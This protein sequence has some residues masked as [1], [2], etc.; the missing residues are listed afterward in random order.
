MSRFLDLAVVAG[1][2]ALLPAVLCCAPVA[3]A[4]EVV[5]ICGD[6][7]ADLE[8]DLADPIWLLRYSLLGGEPP[9]CDG[10][11]KCADVNKDHLIDIGDP[12]YLFGWLL[13]GTEQEPDC[14]DAHGCTDPTASNFDPEA[15]E[16]DGSCEYRGCTDPAAANHDPR[17]TVDDGSCVY[18]ERQVDGFTF[19]ARNA[20]GYPEYRHHE[21]GLIFVLLPG[22]EATLGSPD[23][24]CERN[25]DEGPVHRVSLSPFLIAKYELSQREWRDVLLANPSF[26][27]PG[28]EGEQYLPQELLEEGAWLNLP[29]ETVSWSDCR[30]YCDRTGLEMPT[31]AQWEYACRAGT[32]TPFAF[33]TTLTADEANFWASTGYCGAAGEEPV[34]HTLPINALGPNEFGLYNVHGNV[35]E[36]CADAYSADFYL[37]LVD[38]AL[39]PVYLRETGLRVLRGGGWFGTPRYCRSANRSGLKPAVTTLQIGFRPA[40]TLPE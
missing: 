37:G 38:G 20:H 24:E 19:L 27:Q 5:V 28:A 15:E 12:I 30:E 36:W 10:M 6:V 18:E 11:M 2:F 39:D 26:F 22:G 1:A 14:S 8:I 25:E 13:R 7:N 32:L 33:G 16:D 3:E 35:W 17:A 34:G 23:D 31:E 21:T 4:Q 40:L 29:V 9:R